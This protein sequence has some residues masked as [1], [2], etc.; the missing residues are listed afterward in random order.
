MI[1][2][3]EVSETNKM[4]EHENLDVRT[5]T[6]GISLLDCIDSDLKKLNDNIYKKITTV[7]KDLVSAGNQIEQEFGIPIV[8]KRISVTP[9]HWLEGQPA[10]HRKILQPSQILWMQQL[11]Q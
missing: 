4:V 3:M 9:M 8:N 6:I 5:I 10:R 11:K 7:A 2:I 1:N